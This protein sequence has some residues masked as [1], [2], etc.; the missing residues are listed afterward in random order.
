[1]ATWKKVLIEGQSLT[2]TTNL[3]DNT[4]TLGHFDQGGISLNGSNQDIANVL[5]G[6]GT[7]NLGLDI[8]TLPSNGSPVGGDL[9]ATHDADGT[10]SSATAKHRKV[11]LT[12]LANLFAGTASATGLADTTAVMRVEITNQSENT[13]PAGTEELLAWNGTT[14][15]KISV[16]NVAQAGT[17]DIS[18]VVAGSGL[19]GGATSGSAELNVGAGDLIDVAADTVSV[20]LTEATA[21]TIAAGDFVVFLDGGTAGTH[22]KGSINDV[23]TL[24]AGSGLTAA[25]GVISVDTVAL[26]T[27]TSGNYVADVDSGTNINVTGTAGE[28][29]TFVVNLANNVDVA[30]TLDVTGAATFDSN[31]TIV[32]NLSVTGEVTSTSTTELLVEDKTILIASGASAAGDA[33]NAG[34]VVDTSGLSSHS[35]DAKLNYLESGATFSEWQMVKGQGATPKATTYVAGMAVGTSQSDLN[36]NYDAGLGSLGWDGTNLYIQ[37]A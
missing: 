18:E 6:T 36:T 20:D 25:S 16:S 2:D 29:S 32:G 13:S 34:L 7:V 21:A 8:T 10:G 37:T 11:S 33:N 4:G 28:G 23:A 14:Y 12:N 17:G 31:V 3:S 1:M 5:L 35:A 24:F 30:G 15:E 27:G 9:I 19:T 26:G 22:A